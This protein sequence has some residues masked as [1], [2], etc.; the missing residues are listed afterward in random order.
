VGRRVAILLD[1]RPRAD[2]LRGHA[3]GAAHLPESE[4]PLRAA[5]L[6]PRDEPVDIIAATTEEAARLARELVA[7]GFAHAR[8][9]A[10]SDRS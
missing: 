1:A 3:P 7:R 6:P 8:A 5:E 2:F 4:W 9:C 10:E